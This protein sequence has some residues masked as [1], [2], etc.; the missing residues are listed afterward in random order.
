MKINSV[1]LLGLMLGGTTSAFG[2]ASGRGNA[3]AV[4]I[5]LISPTAYHAPISPFD[6]TVGPSASVTLGPPP[7][8]RWLAPRL[9]I[10][11]HSAKADVSHINVLRA[12]A[13][14]VIGPP[15][16]L[17]SIAPFLSLEAG[18]YRADYDRCAVPFIVE[19]G[20]P[21]PPPCRGSRSGAGWQAGA[22]A[23]IRSRRG[24]APFVQI[25]YM[26]SRKGVDGVVF[27]VGAIL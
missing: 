4:S 24:P 8:K 26:E 11:G 27:L 12:D 1:L 10:S 25:R 15:R 2:Q 20:E 6:R 17:G 3:F 19:D 5:G 22:G 23:V 9:G 21:A 16:P 13:G 14:F 7:G 18:L